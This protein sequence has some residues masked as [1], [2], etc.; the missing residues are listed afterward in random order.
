[1]P[2]GFFSA[3]YKFVRSYSSRSISV[4]G[5][6]SKTWGEEVYLDQ[7]IHINTSSRFHPSLSDR[8][9]SIWVAIFI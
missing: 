7:I 6:I 9:P 5:F 3:S 4:L 2:L 8:F 1:M